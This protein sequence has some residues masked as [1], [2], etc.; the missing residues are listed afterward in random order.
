MPV[1][2]VPDEAAVVRLRFW[3]KTLAA[4]IVVGLGSAL[5]LWARV[6]RAQKDRERNAMLAARAERARAASGGGT[7]AAVV[8]ADTKV[9]AA[10]A[11]YEA[12]VTRHEQARAKAESVKAKADTIRESRERADR[13]GV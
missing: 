8:I 4:G 3:L 6:R 2:H 12:A 5:A 10:E 7:L 13:L 11:R 9:R 1:R